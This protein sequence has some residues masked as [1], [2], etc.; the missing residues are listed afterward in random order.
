VTY[1]TVFPDL[2]PLS[3]IDQYQH[4]SG[5][6]TP[7]PWGNL[8]TIKLKATGS[9]KIPVSIYWPTWSHF[10]LHQNL[11][12]HY[13][14]NLKSH[15]K[16]LH[17]LHTRCSVNTATTQPDQ[18]S[19]TFC[20]LHVSLILTV[21]RPANSDPLTVYKPSPCWDPTAYVANS[22]YSITLSYSVSVSE[23]SQMTAPTD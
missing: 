9:P 21:Q 13:I 11:N 7:P 6:L 10:S 23:N 2:T 12:T 5:N 19:R 17:F 15:T 22:L 8:P 20:P 18:F 3:S 16:N 14:Q 4:I 1:I